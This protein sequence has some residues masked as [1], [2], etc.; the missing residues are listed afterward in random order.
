MIITTHNTI[1]IVSILVNTDHSAP[2]WKPL[3]MTFENLKLIPP[4]LKALREKK[5]KEPTSIQAK[6]IPLILNR[7]DVLGSAQTGTGKTA[8]FAIPI[9]QHLSNDQK[10]I[11]GTKIPNQSILC[12]V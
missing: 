9:I 10:K 7:E 3:K 2:Q 5:Y 6:S 8:A 11:N 12:L 1:A 4:I